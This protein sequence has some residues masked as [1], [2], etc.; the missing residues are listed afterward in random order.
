VDYDSI[1]DFNKAPAQTAPTVELDEKEKEIEK[2]VA[3]RVENLKQYRKD[4]KIEDKWKEADKEYEPE[5]IELTKK[6]RFESDDELGLRSR[7]VLVKD[8]ANDWRSNNSDPTLLVK[9]QTAIAIIIDNNP[10]A[11]LS[12]LNKKYENKTALA[13]SLWKR[14]WNVSGAKEVYKKYV[15]NLAKYGW[16]PGRTFPKKV[17]YDKEVLTEVN[18]SDPSQNV[19]EKRTNVWY[20]DIA[21]EALN[22]FRVW[23]D[24]QSKPY[25]DYSTNDWY[26]EEDFSY[27]AAMVEFGKYP[28]FKK[29]IPFPRDLS[30]DYT[31][32]ESESGKD[33]E[34]KER[35]DIITIGFYENR[36]KDLYAIRVPKL[37]LLL[38]YCPLPND[39]GYLSLW[40]TPWILRSAENPYGVSLWE[41]IKQK[42]GLY[43]KMQNMTMDQLVL[44]IMKMFFYTGTNNLVGDGK[45]KISPG[46]GVNI[47][48]GKIDWMNVPGPGDEAWNGLAQLRKGMDDDS[49]I[50]P[51]LQG[52]TKGQTLGQDMISKEA[53]LKRLK[54]PVDNIADAIEQDAYITLS[55][56]AQVY[57]TPEIKSFTT[58][59]EIRA[60]E[61]ESGLDANVTVASGMNEDGSPQGPFASTFYPQLNLQMDKQGD[62]LVESTKDRFFQINKD[63]PAGDLRWRGIFK[64]IPKSILT[65]SSELEKQRKMEVFNIMAPLLGQPPQ[66]YAKPIKQLLVINEEKPQD[67]LPDMWLQFLEQN[68]GSLFVPHPMPAL[69]GAPGDGIVPSNQTSVQGAAGTTPAAGS[70][71]VVPESQVKT[72][73]APGS[74]G[75]SRQELTRMQ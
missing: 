51:T 39:D 18:E 25:D 64:V 4:L 17:A 53:S 29:Y 43:D 38:H 46:K 63:V 62:K 48:N 54:T 42:K 71:T 12:V 3:G 23:I 58:E 75:A 6:K 13:Y 50:T 45:I 1:K 41:I 44:S 40:H 20:N 9:I 47:I 69:T 59:D 24:E 34:K 49:G 57:S 65:S 5:E 67:W 28:N 36:L 32:D 66:L 8:E 19:Y 10:E 26:H 16:S 35:K 74:T 2:F 22:P 31:D 33:D 14:N 61:Q 55:W 11:S 56:M 27:D 73:S 72:P 30:V 21:R 68:S 15:F 37:N 7:R 60:Y 70:P 52:E